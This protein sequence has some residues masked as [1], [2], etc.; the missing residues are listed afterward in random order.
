MQTTDTSVASEIWRQISRSTKMA[1]GAREPIATDDRTLRIKVTIKRG[2]SHVIYVT[3]D[4]SDTYTVKLV[5]WRQPSLA[6][7]LEGAET[8]VKT[9][10]E[11]SDIYNDNLSEVIYRMCNK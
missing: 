8:V 4:A 9:V 5:T 1:C 3:L 6:K 2:V 11:L 7:R 10:E